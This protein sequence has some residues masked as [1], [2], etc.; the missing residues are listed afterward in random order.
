[1]PNEM[2]EGGLDMP[3]SLPPR[4]LQGYHELAVAPLER[5]PLLAGLRG[6]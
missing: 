5:E 4:S 3:I 6:S 2:R 1:M